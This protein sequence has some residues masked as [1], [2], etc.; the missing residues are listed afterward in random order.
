MNDQIV[1]NPEVIG[2]KPCI[3]GTRIPEYM[4]LELVEAGVSFDEIRAQ[5]YPQITEENI[6]ACIAYARR[7]VQNEV[8]HIASERTV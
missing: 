7:I 1:S 4:I 8:V 6:R 3:V 2:G 5:Y